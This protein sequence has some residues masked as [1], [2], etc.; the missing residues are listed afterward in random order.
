MRETLASYETGRFQPTIEGLERLATETKKPAWWFLLPSD[1][2]E[3]QRCQA[4]FKQEVEIQRRLREVLAAF[5]LQMLR[6]MGTDEGASWEELPPEQL[7]GVI[8]AG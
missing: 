1:P 8:L 5:K 6:D 7:Y 4:A 3:F 2:V